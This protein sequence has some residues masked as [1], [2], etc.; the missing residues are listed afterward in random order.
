MPML[1]EAEKQKTKGRKM[2]VKKMRVPLFIIAIV[3]MAAATSCA[4]AQEEKRIV[5]YEI[6]DGGFLTIGCDVDRPDIRWAVEIF[7]GEKVFAGGK[8]ETGEFMVKIPDVEGRTV[9]LR[10]GTAGDPSL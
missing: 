3:M 10:V 1:G 9:L 8:S 6:T 5:S 2:T 4:S 7:G